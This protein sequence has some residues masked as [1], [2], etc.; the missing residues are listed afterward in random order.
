MTQIYTVAGK[1][2]LRPDAL[3]KLLK[4][5]GYDSPV[6]VA[7]Y[8]TPPT[9]HVY[10]PETETKDPTALVD[11]Y[12]DPHRL[13]VTSQSPADFDGVPVVTADGV[14]KHTLTI[15]KVDLDGAHILEGEESL[16]VLASA[17]VPISR[18]NP[19]LVNGEANIEVG[20]AGNVGDVRIGVLD[21]TK[22]LMPGSLLIRFKNSP[23]A[24]LPKMEQLT[25]DG[26]TAEFA[27]SSLPY[28]NSATVFKDGV[29]Q[30]PGSD[31]TLSGQT[32][33]FASPPAAGAVIVCSY[34]A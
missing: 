23:F 24:M 19:S 14:A 29:F 31:F 25:G 28:P 6:I 4:D 32:V 15:R 20:P 8:G 17:G 34:I 22:M 12:S 26:A 9:V 11:A 10:L 5:N 27:L 16:L 7:Q 21:P 18:S 2:I 1:K 33:T 3:E 13:K 30:V